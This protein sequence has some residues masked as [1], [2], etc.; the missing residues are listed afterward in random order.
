MCRAP[1]IYTIWLAYPDYC[2]VSWV[3][4]LRSSTMKLLYIHGPPFPFLFWKRS[5]IVAKGHR[6]DI[7]NGT[8]GWVVS[9]LLL[10]RM[11]SFVRVLS[12]LAW[13]R[14]GFHLFFFIAGF[15]VCQ[16]PFPAGD[17]WLP[18]QMETS[19]L[20]SVYTY[21]GWEDASDVRS[22]W[23]RWIVVS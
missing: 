10:S 12:P 1:D 11:S 4:N 3:W 18:Y 16:N 20:C 23:N 15:V 13:D 19:S 7:F 6:G 22:P 17:R 8:F 9:S 21:R 2:H 5:E 14:S